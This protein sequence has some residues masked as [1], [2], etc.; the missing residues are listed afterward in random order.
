M[1]VIYKGFDPKIG[2]EYHSGSMGSVLIFRRPSKN[3]SKNKELELP[4]HVPMDAQEMQNQE[5][6]RYLREQHGSV[7][8]QL[9]P[10]EHEARIADSLEEWVR[11]LLSDDGESES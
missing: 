9:T 6:L 8:E 1:A 2:E 3:S 11:T 10:E 4:D 7:P 5:I